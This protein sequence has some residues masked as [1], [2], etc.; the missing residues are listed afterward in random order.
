VEITKEEI[1]KAVKENNIFESK[2][3]NHVWLVGSFT[4][5]KATEKSDIDFLI[6]YNDREL[7]KINVVDWYNVQN[8]I[9]KKFNRPAQLIPLDV[10]EKIGETNYGIRI[11]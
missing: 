2:L 6:D 8:F 9:E 5:D 4:N 11:K 1:I 7:E 10:F 3:F